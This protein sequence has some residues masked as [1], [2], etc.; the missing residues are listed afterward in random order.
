MPN[1]S[2]VFATARSVA[3]I[4]VTSVSMASARSKLGNGRIQGL[5]APPG[6]SDARALCQEKPHVPSH[7]FWIIFMID[8]QNWMR[9]PEL[10]TV[11]LPLSQLLLSEP[12]ALFRPA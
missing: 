4:S 9:N 5:P 7:P 11:F 6:N 2:T 10:V 12:Q 8:L 1:F 3:S